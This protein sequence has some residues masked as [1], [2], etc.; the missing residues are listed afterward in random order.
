[1]G[2]KITCCDRETVDDDYAG[3]SDVSTIETD[4]Q[5]SAV[6]TKKV[7]L[8]RKKK[9]LTDQMNFE[10]M[11]AV[12]SEIDSN[13]SISRDDFTV[14]KLNGELLSQQSLQSL[15]PNGLDMNTGIDYLNMA[16]NSKNKN[17]RKFSDIS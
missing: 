14:T 7:G 12:H 4:R 15:S 13:M 1:M 16:K 8:K 3:K 11:G 2:N 10:D 9:K 5:M 17:S 6:Y